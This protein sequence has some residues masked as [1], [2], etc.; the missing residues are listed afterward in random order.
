[1]LKP[2][3]KNLNKHA[4][5]VVYEIKENETDLKSRYE[6]KKTTNT[7]NKSRWTIL[8]SAFGTRERRFF[9]QSQMP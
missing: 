7:P 9:I 3:Y 4:G 5:R 6:G 8:L 2:G 1:M